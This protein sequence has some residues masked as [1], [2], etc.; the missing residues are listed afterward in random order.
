MYTII[1]WYMLLFL[2]NHKPNSW[3][4]RWKQ[5]FIGLFID[6]TGHWLKSKKYSQ[7]WVVQTNI[8]FLEAVSLMA[9]IPLNLQ[10]QFLFMLFLCYDDDHHQEQKSDIVVWAT[11]TKKAS[12]NKLVTQ[13]Y[14]K[15]WFMQNPNKI[16]SEFL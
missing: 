10:L 9:F 3:W 15:I 5:F 8:R 11:F 6:K 16:I 7:R 1:Q 2:W 13:E 14:L 12:H 4:N